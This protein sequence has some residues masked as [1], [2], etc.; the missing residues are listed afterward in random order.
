MFAVAIDGPSSA[1][2]STVAREVAKRLGLIYVD[3]GALYRAVGYYAV[4]HNADTK[5][6]EQ[7]VPLLKDVELSLCYDDNGV[8]QVYLNGNNVSAEIRL[9]EI[10]MAASDVSAIPEV[11]TFLLSLQRDIA[12]KNNV[13]MD[14]RDI[15]TVILPNA[16][17]K[18]FLTADVAARARRRYKELLEKGVKVEYADVEQDIIARDYQDSNRKTAPL[19][20]SEQSII[21]DNTGFCLEQSVKRVIDII[22]GCRK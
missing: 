15:A 9:P 2:K 20:P 17:V 19:K 8:Q 10:S 1:G 12:E 13:I 6:A 14:G 18:I 7:V 22:E 21:V 16:D 5:S 4:T 3:T 11:R